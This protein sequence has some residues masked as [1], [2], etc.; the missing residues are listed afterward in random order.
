[1]V[2]KMS[3]PTHP[4]LEVLHRYLDA[5]Q[6]F[7]PADVL[8]TFFTPDAVQEER[9]NRLFAE[10]RR[11]DLATMLANSEKGRTLLAEQRY[12]IK[13]AIASGDEVAAEV[14]WIGVLRAGF[15][16]LPAGAQIRAAL[17]MFLTFRDA[18]IASI[19]NYDCYYPF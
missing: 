7:A 15:G 17:G 16:T 9:P 2:V 18:R 8:G 5:L 4:N 11:H 19:R 14:E 1:M 3:S 12:T 6:S 10:G 13:S